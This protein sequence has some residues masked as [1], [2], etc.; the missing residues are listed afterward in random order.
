MRFAIWSVVLAVVAVGIALLARQSDGYVVIVAAPYR[1]ELSLNLLVVLVFAGYFA[2]HLLAR[3]VET[4]V[5]IP[6]RVRAYRAERARTR[7]RQALNDA[8][9]AFFQGRYASAQKSAASALEGEENRGVAAI[10]A[11]RSAHELGRFTE[12]EQFLD[13]AR[14]SA[15]EV[16]QARLTT[17]ADLL[18]SQGRH[19]EALAVLK[20]LSG[21]DARNIRLLSMRLVAETALRRWD[22]VLATGS[23]LAKLGGLSESEA[24]ASRRAAHLGNLSRK[25]HDAPA[26]AA[27]WKHLPG[28]LRVDPTIAATAARFHLALGG[29]AEA[30]SIVESALEKSWD[31]GLVALYADCAG[32]TALPLIERGEKWLRAN[33]RDPALLL[34]LG[35]L[36]MRQELWG[37]AQSYLEASLALEPTHEGH[38]TLAA[39][40]EKLGKPQEAVRHFRRSAELAG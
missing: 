18:L 24:A 35:K 11:A 15:P 36:C 25:A 40:M 21:R 37:K 10:I 27:Y 19:E 12:R 30:Q 4:L 39:L 33:A 7:S 3:L 5:A 20:D 8:L 9:L 6:A 28:E 31:A 14:G 32:G 17:L 29:S 2:F 26:L 1:A 23:S 22:D 13:Q 38:M 34:T 16:D